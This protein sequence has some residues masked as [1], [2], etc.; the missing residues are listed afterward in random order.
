[1]AE[2]TCLRGAGDLIFLARKDDDGQPVLF[3]KFPNVRL[4]FLRGLLGRYSGG[5]ECIWSDLMLLVFLLHLGISLQLLLTS[6]RTVLQRRVYMFVG[7]LRD[8][9]IA[10]VINDTLHELRK[11]GLD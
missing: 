4:Y 9:G 7:R 5:E 6:H 3:E 8:R 10:S 1:M 11:D 2:G